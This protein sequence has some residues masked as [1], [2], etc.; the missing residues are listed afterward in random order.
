MERAV[1]FAHYDKDN[2]IDDYGIYYLKELKKCADYIVFVSC[3]ALPDIEKAKLDGICDFIIAQKHDE[4]DFGSY[5][6]GFLHLRGL[7]ECFDEIVFANDSC[8]G[9]LFDLSPIF[10]KMSAEDCDFWGMTLNKSGFKKKGSRYVAARAPHIQS[11]FLVFKKNVINS[12]CFNSFINSIKKEDDKKDIIINYEI[13]T[14]RIL[15]ENGFKAGY[16]IKKY[17]HINNSAILRW[18]QIITK[19]GMPLLKCSLPRLNNRYNITV[20]GYEEVISSVSNYPIELIHKNVERT[21]V[22]YPDHFKLPVKIRR[23][24]YDLLTELPFI[25][26]KCSFIAIKRLFPMFLD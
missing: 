23:L 4:Y 10:K 13:G 26:R 20:E 17:L 15:S 19:C 16:F 11:Y 6:L 14:T 18:R 7:N 9:P 8:F 22:T 24:V 21:G 12:Q 25:L 3:C 1:V 2:L 5:K